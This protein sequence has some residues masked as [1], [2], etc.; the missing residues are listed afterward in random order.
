MSPPL[1][2]LSPDQQYSPPT[3]TENFEQ[4]YNTYSTLIIPTGPV[5]NF[6]TSKNLYLWQDMDGIYHWADAPAARSDGCLGYSS[7]S[8]Y[9]SAF[10]PEGIQPVCSHCRILPFNTKTSPNSLTTVVTDTV[11]LRSHRDPRLV[12]TITR[13]S[14]TWP[15]N[16]GMVRAAHRSGIIGRA[17]H[18]QATTSSHKGHLFLVTGTR[19]RDVEALWIAS[20]PSHINIALSVTLVHH[21]GNVLGKR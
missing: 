15:S 1:S 8:Y 21:R 19:P 10:A 20:H 16:S 4:Y 11:I 14:F 5:P 3:A 2:E 6:Y 7:P 13:T 9:A 17:L 18:A 12:P